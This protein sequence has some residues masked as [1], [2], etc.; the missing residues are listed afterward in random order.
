VLSFLW[1]ISVPAAS[2]PTVAS[3]ARV[4]RLPVMGH[5]VLSLHLFPRI[6]TQV[7]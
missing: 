3:R 5:R 7:T 4:G 1:R 2:D 6:I